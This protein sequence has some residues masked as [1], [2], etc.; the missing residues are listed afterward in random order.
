[1]NPQFCK[2]NVL[3]KNIGKNL[4]WDIAQNEKNKAKKKYIRLT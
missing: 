2:K 3:D 4:Q 1:M